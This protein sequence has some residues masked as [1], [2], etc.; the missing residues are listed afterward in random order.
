MIKSKIQEKQ[1]AINRKLQSGNAFPEEI[2]ELEGEKETLEDELQEHRTVARESLQYYKEVQ[3]KCSQ[4]WSRICELEV[5]SNKTEAEDE[6]STLKH[7]FTL[8]LSADYQMQ[9]LLPHWGRS[10]QPGSTYYLQKLSY[11]LL[12]IVDHQGNSAAVYIFDERVGHKTADHT[13]FYLLHYLKSTGNIPSWVSRVH[14]FLDNAGSTNKNQY[15]SACLEVVQRVLQYL[16]V[17]FMIPGHTKFAPDI[18]FAK[19]KPSIQPTCLIRQTCSRLQN[20]LHWS[21]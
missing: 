1:T 17:S 5:K 16:R 3:E 6:L 7:C 4:Q 20:S 18:L 12:G 19:I 8:L 10:P 9:K 21:S 11:D 2:K 14:M 13:F 15:L